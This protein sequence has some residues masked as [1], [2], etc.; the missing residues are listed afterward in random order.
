M[1]AG[2]EGQVASVV[3]A[4]PAGLAVRVGQGELAVQADPVVQADPAA[5]PARQRG[6]PTVV[7]GGRTSAG[8]EAQPWA[9]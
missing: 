2:L 5:G 4:V 7:L 6:P 9:V 3:L 1:Q 8:Q